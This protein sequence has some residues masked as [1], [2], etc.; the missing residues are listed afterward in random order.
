MIITSDL[1]KQ[2]K[3][4]D[5]DV[6]TFEKLWPYGFSLD[7]SQFVIG[8]R[9]DINMF[10][11]GNLLPKD[12]LFAYQTE[13]NRLTKIYRRSFG[14]TSFYYQ[15]KMMDILAEFNNMINTFDKNSNV[16]KFDESLSRY[17]KTVE[18]LHHSYY[19]DAS[20]LKN[21][22]LKDLCRIFVKTLNANYPIKPKK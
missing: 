2:C 8:C 5:S 18:D 4:T 13:N 3:A 6:K 7:L 1:L 16:S 9:A 22:H 14:S 12:L 17:H 20:D 10:C 21:M 15:N 11:L 19:A